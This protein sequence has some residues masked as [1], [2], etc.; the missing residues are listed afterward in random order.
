MRWLTSLALLL[1]L[2]GTL[3]HGEKPEPAAEPLGRVIPEFES[4]LTDS[5]QQT[6]ELFARTLAKQVSIDFAK[7]K[8]RDAITQFEQLAGIPIRIDRLAL[9]ELGVTLDAEVSIRVDEVSLYSALR[10]TL[11]QHEL[12]YFVEEDSLLITTEK[13]YQERLFHH[14]YAVPELV[15]NPADHDSLIEA[16]TATVEPDSWEELGGPATI[17]PFNN[18]EMVGQ[19]QANQVRIARLFQRLE[20]LQK[21]P[22]DPYP[23]SSRLVSL[24]P[25]QTIAI[26]KALNAE[27]MTVEF[28]QTPLIDIIE[29]LDNQGSMTFYL[30]AKGLEEYGLAT[31]MP[32][33]LS[34]GTYTKKRLLDMITQQTELDWYI[35]G[36]MVVITNADVVESDLEVRL[37]PVRDLACRGLDLTDPKVRDIVFPPEMNQNYSSTSGFLH[38][39]ADA[40]DP[41][42]MIHLP[43]YD[44]VI[45]LLKTTVEAES[46]AELGGPGSMY[47][48]TWK[49]D[50]LVI[51]Q[52]QA[53]HRKIAAALT[54]MR[55]QQKPIDTKAFLAEIDRRNQEI[56]VRSHIISGNE[57]LGIPSVS[58]SDRKR[59]VEQIRDRIASDSWDG[60][61]TYVT[62]MKDRIVVR[63]RR[64]IQN[65]VTGYLLDLGVINDFRGHGCRGPYSGGYRPPQISGDK[66]DVP[67]V[68]IPEVH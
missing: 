50:C 23:T 65:Q 37:Y 52:T 42:H 40:T 67:P 41:G 64:S 49:A 68:P 54:L 20:A 63:H 57:E 11:T 45:E 10:W 1:C 30:D 60:K 56:Y 48:F 7:L 53:V 16:V 24:F 14:F 38:L 4:G 26:D 59:L 44:A 66:N 3:I 21:S 18:G 12:S 43:D 47:A 27:Q 58:E 28:Q 8:L 25:E 51:A 39:Y 6:N 22:S 32:V 46:W 29:H 31:T 15:G 2:S 61:T 62:A 9:E 36:D 19:T 17:A 35:A 55:K 33:T 13:E 5:I 34:K